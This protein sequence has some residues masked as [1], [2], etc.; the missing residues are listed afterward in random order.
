MNTT[1]K[2]SAYISFTILAAAVMMSISAAARAQE[3]ERPKTM[4][5]VFGAVGMPRGFTARL[6]VANLG[7]VVPDA[8]ECEARLQFAGVTPSRPGPET[9]A[10]LKPGE[11]AVLEI[12]AEK[13]IP[14]RTPF[15]ARVELG[16]IV[17]VSPGATGGRNY[18]SASLQIVN[19]ATGVTTNLA[20]P[21]ASLELPAVQ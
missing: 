2:T 17:T 16:A 5:H 1:K 13:V 11:K 10:L 6:V 8:P 15:N 20:V 7:A 4:Q 18:C 9:K 12:D 21:A 3:P 19:N 14:E